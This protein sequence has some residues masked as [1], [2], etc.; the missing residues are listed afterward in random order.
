MRIATK[1]N[2]VIIRTRYRDI[3]FEEARKC[4]YGKNGSRV[5][6]SEWD[7]TYRGTPLRIHVPSQDA[8]GPCSGP[9]FSA[10]DG[11]GF[12][13]PHIAEIGD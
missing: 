8:S 4:F 11:V 9:F 6:E 5:T 10:V 1:E 13:C 7:A 3:P 12:V 2:S